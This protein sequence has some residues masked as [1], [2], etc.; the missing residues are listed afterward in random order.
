MSV[1]SYHVCCYY[2]LVDNSFLYG[3]DVFIMRGLHASVDLRL[4]DLINGGNK[5]IYLVLYYPTF[6]D[7]LTVI[8]DIFH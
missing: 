2:L 1:G 3:R 6:F 4:L 7:V 5:E 8:R